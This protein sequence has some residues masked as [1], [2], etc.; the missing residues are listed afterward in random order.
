MYLCKKC[1][2]EFETP[3]KLGGHVTKAHSEVP[4]R[5]AASKKAIREGS[6][7]LKPTLCSYCG[8][9]LPYSKRSQ[10]FCSHS[11]SAAFN[12]KL[13]ASKVERFCKYC[14]T[15]LQLHY[16]SDPK[17]FC[18]SKCAS[19]SKVAE[20]REAWLSTGKIGSTSKSGNV[21]KGKYVRDYIRDCQD[22]KCA[23]CGMPPQWNNIPLTFVLDHINGIS[24]DNRR[25]N[26]RLICSNCDSQLDTY[27][28]RNKGRGRRSL[29][30]KANEGL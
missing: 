7:A 18:N 30:F 20:K 29:G 16:A 10:K 11:C 22:N 17:K 8:E 24:T 28:A 9:S 6:Y 2:K 3:Q 13:R 19:N 21:V 12:N 1:G 14:K 23:I 15:P 27:K 25:V 26:L 4:K 5:L